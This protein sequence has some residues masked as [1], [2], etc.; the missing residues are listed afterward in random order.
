M[1][2][3]ACKRCSGI[4]ERSG[5][6]SRMQESTSE[7]QTL[8]SVKE[9]TALRPSQIFRKA[10]L[11]AVVLHKS[12][13]LRQLLPWKR[14]RADPFCRLSKLLSSGG[15]SHEQQRW[16]HIG[17][18]EIAFMFLRRLSLSAVVGSG[19]HVISLP[20]SGLAFVAIGA[21]CCPR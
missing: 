9:V 2:A 6:L 7:K 11:H 12:C 8:D 13:T 3:S 4:L 15:M 21:V 10:C 20:L 5:L 17:W 19:F 18:S 16:L 1:F 14:V